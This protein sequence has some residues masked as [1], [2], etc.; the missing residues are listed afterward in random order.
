MGRPLT[1]E[2]TAELYALIDGYA[3]A[4]PPLYTIRYAS[5]RGKADPFA[6]S[7]MG[8]ACLVC[9]FTL[10]TAASALA[11]RDAGAVRRR[12]ASVQNGRALYEL[13][14]LLA[15]TLLGAAAELLVLAPD[16]QG[17]LRGLPAVA[18][19]SLCFTS[20][21]I[22]L[23]RLGSGE[24]RLDALAPVLALLLCLLG[25][26]FMDLSALPKNIEA[27]TLLSPAA[28]ALRAYA[29]SLPAAL[30]L[31]AESAAFATAA[32]FAGRRR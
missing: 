6:P 11:G 18:A 30:A 29:G 12:M 26:C 32:A 5:G 14:E 4:L 15:L 20:L 1:G 17:A 7:P 13:T 31:L 19:S 3:D 9:L 27:L 25:G 16:L 28:V 2:E 8:F 23:T 21:A 24:G 22:L 10:L